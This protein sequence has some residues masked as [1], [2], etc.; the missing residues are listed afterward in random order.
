MAG[1]RGGVEY[2]S[3]SAD[4]KKKS[5]KNFPR[6]LPS[7]LQ[8]ECVIGSPLAAKEA[9]RVEGARARGTGLAMGYVLAIQSICH[10]LKKT[11]VDVRG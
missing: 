7:R 9:S 8:P 10:K 2:E 6:K 5:E 3:C 11:Q 1:S 4:L